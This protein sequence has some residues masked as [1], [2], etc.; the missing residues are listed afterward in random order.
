MQLS[1]IS[2]AGGLS[3]QPLSYTPTVIVTNQAELNTELAKSAAALQGQVI[4]VQ[5]NATPYIITRNSTPNLQNKDF[6]SLGLVICG[7]GS[8]MPVFSSLDFQ[9]T[10]NI[11]LYNIEVYE[12]IDGNLIIIRSGVT[13]FTMNNCKIHS[14]YYDP[15]GNYGAYQP[16]VTQ[17][18]AIKTV[19]AGAG[20]AISNIYITNCEFYNVLEVVSTSQGF[21]GDF[22]FIGNL[23]HTFYSGALIFSTQGGGG[24]TKINWNIFY[25]GYGKSSDPNIGYGTAPHVDFIQPRAVA[26][27]WTLEI[28]G[29]IMFQGNC[30]SNTTQCIF[31]DDNHIVGDETHYYTAIVKGNICI[32]N[33]LHGISILQSKNS[34]VIGNTVIHADNTATIGARVNVGTGTSSY[35]NGNGGGNVIKN[36]VAQNISGPGSTSTNNNAYSSYTTEAL[37]SLFVGP[38]FTNLY[39]VSEVLAALAMLVGGPLDQTV[40]IGADGTGYVNYAARTINT[41]ME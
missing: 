23:C 4:G 38:T 34:T 41:T 21:S 30:R 11:T 18:T 33:S 19:S 15:N 9:G 29:N 40:N 12:E 31:M 1:N 24:T 16:K 3:V 5:Y 10:K 20:A 25:E 32:T 39:T 37:A 8:T 35:P 13:N 2:I 36:T 6:G 7:V 28:I 26:Q 14:A 27:N 22:H 17:A